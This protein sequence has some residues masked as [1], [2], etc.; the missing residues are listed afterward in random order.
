MKEWFMLFMIMWLIVSGNFI[1][2]F[3]RFALLIT[4]VVL[5]VVF[6]KLREM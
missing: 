4:A 5:V 1:E 2:V 6:Y 3:L